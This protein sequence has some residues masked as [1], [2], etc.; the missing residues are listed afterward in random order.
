MSSPVVNPSNHRI[1]IL[2]LAVLGGVTVISQARL[3]TWGSQDV[4]S[5]AKKVG[6]YSV[7]KVLPAARGRILDRQGRPLA[8]DSPVTELTIEFAKVPHSAGFWMALSSAVGIPVA[9][10]H[11]VQGTGKKKRAWQISLSPSQKDQFAKVRK[12][13]RADGIGLAGNGKREVPVGDAA[14]PIVGGFR[15]QRDPNGKPVLVQTGLESTQND[16]LKGKDG[17]LVGFADEEG[18]ILPNRIIETQSEEKE[19]GQQIVTTI[20]ANVQKAAYQALEKAVVLNAATEG[21]AVVLD[22]RTGDVLALANYPTFPWDE[23]ANGTGVPFGA[24]P[25]IKSRFE[26]GSTFKILTLAKALDEGKVTMESHV[27]CQLTMAVGNRTIGCDRSHGAHGTVDPTRA[28]AKSCNVSAATWALRIGHASFDGYMQKLGLFE[29]TGIELGGETTGFRN[30]TEYAKQ[31][32]L[33]T[34]GFGQSVTCTPIGLASAF[35]TIANRGR[36][37]PPRLLRRIGER[38]TPTKA[39]VPV[40][41]EVAADE[42]LHAM[43][44]VVQTSAGTGY[45]LR[46]PGYRIAGK[47]GTAEKVGEVDP[48]TKK[49]IKGYVAN[50]IGFVPAERPQAVILVMVNNPKGGRY[51]GGLVAGPA[52]REIALSVIK[53]LRIPPSTGSSGPGSI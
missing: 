31:L 15:I 1:W 6:R 8:Q 29:K 20:D 43:E 52:F 38:D 13:W 21:S 40:I 37:V 30:S 25:A 4:K 39:A 24:N 10:L 3:Q 7:E 47:T 22:P 53:N 50:F 27:T 51:Y 46:I 44:A 34:W 49:P 35:S 16:R 19:D 26:P 28:I 9:E 33:A 41:S 11:A 42:V 48:I 5:K 18:N 2:V 23:R 36:R 45:S 17:K 14:S 12:F 32:Q